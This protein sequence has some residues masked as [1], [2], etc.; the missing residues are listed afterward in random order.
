M[1]TL[2]PSSGELRKD[3]EREFM[4]GPHFMQA[5]R[6]TS[7]NLGGKTVCPKLDMSTP[8]AIFGGLF[9]AAATFAICGTLEARSTQVAQE[10]TAIH[11]EN[12][13]GPADLN[14]VSNCSAQKNTSALAPFKQE[15]S[16]KSPSASSR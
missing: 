2:V 12:V 8:L 4:N 16:I 11:Q 1:K 6:L 14:L 13:V 15:C 10:A 9:F 3:T 5:P 7:E